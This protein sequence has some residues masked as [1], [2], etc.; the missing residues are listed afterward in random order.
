MFQHLLY[1]FF[2]Q[3]ED[4]IRDVAVTGFRRVLFRSRCAAALE[5]GSATR[6]SG[7]ATATRAKPWV[8]TSRKS[9]PIAA[10][11]IAWAGGG[12]YGARCTPVCRSSLRGT[13]VQGSRSLLR[14][15][16]RDR[17][18]EILQHVHVRGLHEVVVEPGLERAALV[19][20]APVA[21]QGDEEDPAEARLLPQLPGELVPVH[22]REPEVGE[23]DIGRERRRRPEGGESV[24]G[25]LHLVT[26]ALEHRGEALGR[27]LMVLHEEDI[28]TAGGRAGRSGRR[29]GGELGKPGR[30][31]RQPRHELA[32]LLEP[33]APRLD[34]PAV[35]LDQR[36]YE[37]ESDAEPA[38]RAVE[39]G[40]ALH[41]EVEDVGQ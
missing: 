1:G 12:S 39:R 32:A 27:V 14:A 11:I 22:A 36:A 6:A 24:E 23:H 30:E 4:G 7:T 9:S 10:I 29:C 40:V 26:P 31:R 33:G 21:R 28:E 19:L 25:H 15:P 5:A 2:F 17:S 13:S 41:E 38:A 37:R 3:A 18:E 34:S 8:R 20:L 16:G 35:Q